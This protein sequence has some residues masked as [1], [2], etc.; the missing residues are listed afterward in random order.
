VFYDEISTADRRKYIADH[1]DGIARHGLVRGLL[2]PIGRNGGRL[3]DVGCASGYYSVEFARCGGRAT[4]V[5]IS[6]ASVTLTRRRAANAG[7]SSSTNFVVG[8]MR[9]LSLDENGFDAVLMSEVIEHVREQR[10]ALAK[11]VRLLRPRGRLILTT[12]NA[13]D[14]LPWWKRFRRRGAA[15]PEDAEVSVDRLASTQSSLRPE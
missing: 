1:W 14:A 11:A 2:K 12:P 10:E 9:Q 15:S 5:D 7:V 8:D 6:E 3:L 4:G 13:L